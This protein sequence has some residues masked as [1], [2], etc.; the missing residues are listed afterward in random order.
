VKISKIQTETLSK[1]V[2]ALQASDLCVCIRPSIGTENLVP[3]KVNYT[4]IAVRVTVMNEVQFLLASEPRK[5]LK[6]RPFY[7]YSLS[8]KHARKTTPRL[9]LP[10]PQK[11]LAAIINKRHP[12]L[13]I[14]E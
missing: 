7:V 10:S 6:P 2:I 13:E 4:K 5:P 14:Q 1:N 8:K 11:D 9:R 3:E 12:R